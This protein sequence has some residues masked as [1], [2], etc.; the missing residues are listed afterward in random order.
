[1]AQRPLGPQY[2]EGELGDNA[3]LGWDPPMQGQPDPRAVGPQVPPD[4]SMV[5]FGRELLGAPQPQQPRPTPPMQPPTML[6]KPPSEKDLAKRSRLIPGLVSPGNLDISN[7][8]PA[9]TDQ[10]DMALLKPVA[11][12]TPQGVVL[13]PTVVNG[14]QIPEHEAIQMYH[15]TGQ[16]LGMFRNRQAA[17]LYAQRLQQD[18][19][20]ESIMP[21]LQASIKERRKLAFEVD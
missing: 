4:M 17:E 11:I 21:A 8:V 10:G 18:L 3:F 13:I 7:P 14:Q 1:M 12:E 5:N 2:E 15:Q 19:Y 20:M 16:H 6:R 9:M